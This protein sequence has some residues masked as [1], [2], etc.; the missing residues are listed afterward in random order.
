MSEAGAEDMD[1]VILKVYFSSVSTLGP[2]LDM[3]G[4]GIF[5][6][7]WKPPDDQAPDIAGPMLV[8]E[9]GRRGGEVPPITKVG[10]ASLP[11]LGGGGPPVTGQELEEQWRGGI[12]ER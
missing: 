6:P 2:W 4:P 8:G 5:Q 9:K 10:H 12:G 1:R 11:N 3:L 7:R